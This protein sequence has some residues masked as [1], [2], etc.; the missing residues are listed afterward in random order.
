M[1]IYHFAYTFYIL[2][3][4]TSDFCPF[5]FLPKSNMVA[6]KWLSELLSGFDCRIRFKSVFA[7]VYDDMP[8]G[9]FVC[10]PLR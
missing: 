2:L 10:I 8:P 9:A 5:G 4:E 6:K 1:K 7:W 3:G